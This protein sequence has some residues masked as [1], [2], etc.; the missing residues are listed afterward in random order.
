MHF[1][2]AALVGFKLAPLVYSSS[3]P[4]AIGVKVTVPL[5]KK[6]RSAIVLSEVEKPPFNCESAIEVSDE[7]LDRP[8]LETAKF[9]AKY[10]VC[11][12]GEVFTQFIAAKKTELLPIAISTKITL[13]SR[14]N[15]AL[16]FIDQN[17]VTLLFG[18]TGS[19]KSEIYMKLFERVL[20]ENKTALF[21]MPEISL[22]PQIEKRL[23]AEFGDLVSIWHSKITPTKK[24][25]VLEQIA[26]GKTRIVAGARSALFLP[27]PN[28]GAIVI[29]EE[30]DDSYKSQNS[31]RINARDAAIVLAKNLAIPVVLGSATPTPTSYKRFPH[32]RL[33]GGFFDEA[34]RETR[35]VPSGG[36]ELTIEAMSAI[37]QTLERKKQAIVFL[38]TRANFKYLICAKCGKTVECPFCEVGMSLHTH[39]RALVCHYCNTHLSVPE[40]C[41]HCQSTMLR[42]ER[43]GTAEIAQRLQNELPHA[44][45]AQFDRDTIK[46]DRALR[47][48]LERFN[49]HEIDI[50]VGT[51]MLSKGHDYH[52]VELAIVLGLDR[53]LAAS[54]YRAKE[55]A[56]TLLI[57]LSG[58]AGRKS[59]ALVIAQ[60]LNRAAFLPYLDDYELFL[61]EEIAARKEL[62]PP[63]RRLLRLVFA[64]NRRE[65]AEAALKLTI[66]LLQSLN[67][68]EV[69]GFGDCPIG[70]VK[71]RYRLFVLIRSVNAWS[72]IDAARRVDCPFVEI[73]I[74]PLSFT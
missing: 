63:A 21:L 49:N 58:R 73:E 52:E 29:D 4:I 39:K 65:K 22:T 35:F 70:R 60:T 28:L 13:S 30:H 41:P 40:T 2:A 48:V 51:Q 42:A 27:M 64:H 47:Q 53:L 8:Y 57:Q 37:A 12:I 6:P 9:L 44:R 68:V 38:P 16:N 72:L 59:H 32:F 14:Q 43:H 31:P 46:T 18:D 61:Q 26:N 25:A 11:E 69:V 33:R 62:Y 36:D 55:R 19:G 34:G 20:N 56:L 50:L 67:D 3:D 71:M 45:V 74:D 66:D 54:D 7:M 5:A 1:Y 10:F 24:T 15:E 23:K 17:P